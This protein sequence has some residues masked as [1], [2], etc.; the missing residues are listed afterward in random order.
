MEENAMTS[1]S[2]APGTQGIDV[3]AS[4]ESIY[5]DGIVGLPSRFLARVT[6]ASST[7]S[8]CAKSCAV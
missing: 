3:Q 2:Q 6:T 4:V 7:P 5:T 8:A 1:T